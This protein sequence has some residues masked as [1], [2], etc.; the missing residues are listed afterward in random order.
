MG[1]KGKEGKGGKRRRD[2]VETEPFPIDV[3]SAVVAVCNSSFTLSDSP[4]RKKTKEGREERGKE[5]GTNRHD[6]CKKGGDKRWEF[7]GAHKK[8]RGGE[9][10][11]GLAWREREEVT[12]QYVSGKEGNEVIRNEARIPSSNPVC[13]FVSASR[14]LLQMTFT[15]RGNRC[16]GR[17]VVRKEGRKFVKKRNS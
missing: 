16:E 1:G 12:G 14:S 13:A 5:E 6:N 2:L 10:R 17:R 3:D 4:E 15:W 7:R 11:E 9:R 8:R